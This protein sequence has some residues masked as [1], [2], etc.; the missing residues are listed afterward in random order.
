MSADESF[1]ERFIH[2]VATLPMTERHRR[3]ITDEYIPATEVMISEQK[4]T[5]WKYHA[6]MFTGVVSSIAVTALISIQQL[7][8]LSKGEERAVFWVALVMSVISTISLKLIY[9]TGIYKQYVIGGMAA[10]RMQAEGWSYVSGSGKYKNVLPRDRFQ[11]F[12]TSFLEIIVVANGEKVTS[13]EDGGSLPDRLA[14]LPAE[15]SSEDDTVVDIID[16]PRDED[17]KGLSKKR[18]L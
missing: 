12:A 10:A 15:Q 17:A 8:G 2:T 7:S 14:G 6:L 11:L 18:E 4:Y 16:I 9:S 5:S 1:R 13:G 3:I